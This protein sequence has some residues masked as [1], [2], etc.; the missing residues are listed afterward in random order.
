VRSDAPGTGKLVLPFASSGKQLR[1]YSGA[2]PADAHCAAAVQME[3]VYRRGVNPGDGVMEGEGVGSGVTVPVGV[4]DGVPLA[5]A[6]PVRECDAP[7]EKL[8][9][10]V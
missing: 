1:A 8:P 7:L 9:D 3:E 10:G 6:V 4:W 5:V 2:A